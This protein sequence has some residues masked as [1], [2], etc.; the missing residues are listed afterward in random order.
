MICLRE[1]EKILF[2]QRFFLSIKVYTRVT[3]ILK[4]KLRYAWY[5]NFG[6]KD[7]NVKFDRTIHES[8]KRVDSEFENLCDYEKGKNLSKTQI[9]ASRVFVQKYVDGAGEGTRTPASTKPTSYLAILNLAAFRY[10][11][12]AGA[13][14]TPP[15]RLRRYSCVPL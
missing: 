4:K 1:E 14:T 7:Y 6:G 8:F 9:A 15:P 11:L 10:D 3:T 5:I 12:E 13:I 2:Q